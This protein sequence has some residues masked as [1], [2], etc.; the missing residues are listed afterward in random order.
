MIAD[1][2]SEAA[3]VLADGE[4]QAE[5]RLAEAR[6]EAEANVARARAT[7][8]AEG[9]IAAARDTARRGAAARMAVL[10]ARREVYEELCARA[11]E[12][13]LALRTDPEYPDLLERLAEAARQALGSDAEVDLDP[14]GVG[15]A[16][17]RAGTR[18]IDFTLPSL[19]N[20]CIADLGPRLQRLWR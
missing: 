5:Q 7:G 11:H 18:S 13:V 15:G 16:S 19:T 14:P 6:A 4:R 8:E 10:S 3:R 17:A 1:A 2:T 12:S 9:R 20:R